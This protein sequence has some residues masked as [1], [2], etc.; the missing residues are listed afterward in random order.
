MAR[1][2]ARPTRLPFSPDETAY[3]GC[4]W[5]ARRSPTCWDAADAEDEVGDGTGG[6]K[7]ATIG[8]SECED[9]LAGKR[10]QRYCSVPPRP[11]PLPCQPCIPGTRNLQID[12]N[13]LRTDLI[14][15]IAARTRPCPV[16]NSIMPG[17][18]FVPV[19][20]AP[21]GEMCQIMIW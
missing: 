5:A 9:Q 10:A 1:R 18:S 19:R 14:V 16:P 7:A 4:A 20:Y 15:E 2:R 8:C 6:D 21:M 13:S 17:I 12:Q 3:C 11:N